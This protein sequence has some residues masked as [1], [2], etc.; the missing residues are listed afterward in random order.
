MFFPASA[1]LG[2]VFDIVSRVP[3]KAKAYK[4]ARFRVFSFFGLRLKYEPHETF[5]LSE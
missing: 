2:L 5:A 1:A 4:S 3:E